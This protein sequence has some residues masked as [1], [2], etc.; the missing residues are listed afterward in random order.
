MQKVII[1]YK[2]ITD[3]AFFLC[4]LHVHV[5]ISVIK[6]FELSSSNRISTSVK[7]SFEKEKIRVVL[8]QLQL[9]NDIQVIYTFVDTNKNTLGD[10]TIRYNNTY[11]VYII[12]S[13]CKIIP[14]LRDYNIL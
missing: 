12:Y 13:N 4:T 6:C 14:R 5:I 1:Y 2:F 9:S 7:N 11:T 8:C 3:I 10:F